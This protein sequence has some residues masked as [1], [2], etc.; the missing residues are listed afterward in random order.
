MTQLQHLDIKIPN[1]TQL[2]F[3]E[4]AAT[5]DARMP[6]NY[7]AILLDFARPFVAEFQ[8][9]STIL[10]IGTGTGAFIPVLKSLAPD[11]QLFSVD[12]AHAML[13]H[14][15][16]RIPNARLLQADVHQLPFESAAI[17][18]VV[19]HNSF[20]HFRKK[21][22]ALDEIK[23]VL[24]PDGKLMILH[25]NSREFV[26]SIHTRAGEPLHHDL[27][28]T[29]EDMRH[30]LISGGWADV[31]VEDAPHRYIARAQVGQDS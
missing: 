27:L 26:N 5:W 18:L 22:Q 1:L 13:H 10:E 19:C 2:Y 21:Q 28:P 4:S 30:L 8:V 7:G 20:P 15:Q 31:E 17:D 6:P 24:R 11:A 12:L 29:G 16:Q 25:N 23:R 14:A 3:E 9:A